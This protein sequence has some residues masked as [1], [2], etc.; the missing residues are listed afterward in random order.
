MPPDLTIRPATRADAADIFEMLMA[1]FD[2][3]RMCALDPRMAA[4][5]IE[6]V[7]EHEAAWVMHA[8]GAMVGSCGL[9]QAGMWYSTD[10]ILVTRWLYVVPAW[11]DD[12]KAWRLLQAEIVAL[13]PAIG[14]PILLDVNDPRKSRRRTVIA[15]QMAAVEPRG[16]RL[17]VDALDM[18]AL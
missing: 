8:A 11:R 17:M 3:G 18:E 2:E 13:A 6:R 12:G 10:D 7:C 16:V 9:A 4:N 1:M 14:M 5:E 15:S